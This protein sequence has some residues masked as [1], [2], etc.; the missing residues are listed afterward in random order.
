MGNVSTRDGRCYSYQEALAK[1]GNRKQRK[2]GNNTWMV[3]HTGFIAIKLHAT[4]VV[5]IWPDNT[6][7]LNSGGY[8]TV[9]TKDRL[10]TYGPVRV[11]QK[12]FDWFV[13]GGRPFVDYMIVDRFGESVHKYDGIPHAQV[14]SD[15][16]DSSV[17]HQKID[18]VNDESHYVSPEAQATFNNWLSSHEM[19]KAEEVLQ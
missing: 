16:V 14:I 1:L 19:P 8:K 5:E 12:N 3:K 6:Y 13:S 7:V 15:E 9:T 4:N 11:W 18:L 10:N 2:L 17:L